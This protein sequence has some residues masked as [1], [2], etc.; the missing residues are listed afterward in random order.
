MPIAREA[1]RDADGQLCRRIRITRQK[2]IAQDQV[3]LVVQIEEVGDANKA[4]LARP[5]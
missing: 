5:A 2:S 3:D 4:A 1:G